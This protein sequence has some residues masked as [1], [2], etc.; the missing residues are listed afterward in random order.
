MKK[1]LLLVLFVVLPITQLTANSVQIK[2]WGAF[3]SLLDVYDLDYHSNVLWAATKGGVFRYNFNTD[4]Y[5]N[6]N[7]ITGLSELSATTIYIDQESNLVYTGYESGAI[8][9][10]DG[11]NWESIYDIKNGN[12]A[13]A[14]IN[15]IIRNQDKILVAGDFGLAVFDPQN[16]VFVEDVKRFGDFRIG[17]AVNK[18]LLNENKIWV[19][20]ESGVA[21]IDNK[22]SIANRLDW[23]NYII[24]D[25]FLDK[26]IND[27]TLF[28]NEI[29]ISTPNTVNKFE[30]DAFIEIVK[31][32]APDINGLVIKGNDLFYYTEKRL[33]NVQTNQNVNFD[34]PIRTVKSFNT[35]E[36]IL[37]TKVGIRI[38]DFNSNNDL[39]PNTPGS[40][41]FLDTYVQ[42]DG[43]IWVATGGII[44]DGTLRYKNGEWI[45]Y[46]VGNQFPQIT[47]NATV[48]V[49]GLANNR[50]AI[51]TYGDG[52]M[53]FNE[54]DEVESINPSNS[55]MVSI[56]GTG[57][58]AIIGD[59]VSDNQGNDWIVNWG[60][61]GSGPLFVIRQPDG[62]YKTIFNCTGTTRRSYLNAVI[63]INGTIWTSTSSPNVIS[64]GGEPIS[65]IVYFNARNGLEN[66]A[67]FVCGD[68]TSTNSDIN[69]NLIPSLAVDKQNNLWVG[70]ND[71]VNRI[72]NP[73]AVL[74]NSNLLITD[75]RALSGQTIRDI[76][77]DALNN[78]WFATNNGIFVL[79]PDGSE[80]IQQINSNNSPLPTD[81]IYSLSYN[82]E[83]GIV[84]IGT[85]SGLY[86]IETT[87]IKALEDYDIFSYPS[88]F[89]PLID[90][91]LTIDGLADDSEIKIVTID[92]NL[93]A[94]LETT[95][96]VATWD[97][98]NQFG[99]YA[100]PGVYLLISSSASSDKSGIAKIAVVRK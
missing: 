75:V 79:S 49:N 56:S 73:S 11:Q 80:I 63:D 85:S 15:H 21:V 3:T 71:G 39:A 6:F 57:G 78:K 4:S 86:Y 28:N 94:N 5:E 91:Q 33:V 32:D 23:K 29:Y 84:Y 70:S 13:S 24:D 64:E 37:G 68:L 50:V 87:A 38:T 88:P 16:R 22:A 35:N 40:N 67:D 27:I 41:S 69:S 90:K 65:G 26:K 60:N 7:L 55:P 53:I 74:T 92:G 61:S 30:N 89:D 10:F 62:N 93:I 8:D 58:F 44:G 42:K 36:V 43:T 100:S 31:L 9:I 81:I 45:Q 95:G 18:V 51:S 83:T 48:K 52:I 99:E 59:V 98:K 54:N 96:R 72:I 1:Y 12:F 19:A 66:S 17:T 76:I 25:G 47:S 20:T 46:K 34:N 82:E 77:V 14:N 2:S 97:G